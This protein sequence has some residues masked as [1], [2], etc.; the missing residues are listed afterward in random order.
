MTKPSLKELPKHMQ[1]KQ[2]IES[3][4]AHEQQ[5]GVHTYHQCKCGRQACRSN[6]CVLCWEEILEEIK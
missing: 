2:W 6:M 5:E 4:I 1:T 3:E